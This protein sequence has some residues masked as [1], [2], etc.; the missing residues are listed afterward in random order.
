MSRFAI[1]FLLALVGAVA[2][3][4]AGLRRFDREPRMPA[5]AAAI[6]PARRAPEPSPADTGFLGLVTARKSVS[7]TAPFSAV[8]E[9][10]MVHLGDHVSAGQEVARLDVRGVGKEVSM[11][12]A[13]L[14]AA[15]A[16]RRRA[17]AELDVS[18]DWRSRT[19]ALGR[20]VSQEE[21]VSATSLVAQ[22]RSRVDAAAAV[23]AQRRAHLEKTREALSDASL[24]A[25]VAGTVAARFSEPGARLAPGQ[26][27]I[28][29]LGDGDP[30][31][32]L[33]SPPV[34]P[35]GSGSGSG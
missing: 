14:R 2:G 20:N 18:R 5:V 7:L 29:L 9:D 27:V 35:I 4:A 19:R 6:G 33:P 17:L 13:D 10:L 26:P 15:E 32:R 12:E 30:I 28:R 16:D 31:V 1:V 34:R 21:H 11:A 23:A 24:R 8:L 22:A 25:P 3:M